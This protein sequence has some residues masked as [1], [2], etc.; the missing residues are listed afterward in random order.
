M[1]QT[2]SGTRR[3]SASHGALSNLARLN[4]AFP[5][6]LHFRQKA[7]GI[8]GLCVAKVKQ[9]PAGHIAFWA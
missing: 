2:S 9:Y 1:V 7:V 6:F 5:I 8:L 3:P 4:T